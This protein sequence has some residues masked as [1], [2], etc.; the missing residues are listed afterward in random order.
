MSSGFF[1]ELAHETLLTR[2]QSNQLSEPRSHPPPQAASPAPLLSSKQ[3]LANEI[4]ILL[5]SPFLRIHCTFRR[6]SARR[7]TVL[8]PRY[9]SD[10]QIRRSLHEL[11]SICL[12]ELDRNQSDPGGPVALGALCGVE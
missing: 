11:L 5:S 9:G 4:E 12:W 10:E 6:R 1:E 2:W 8:R 3:S 7:G